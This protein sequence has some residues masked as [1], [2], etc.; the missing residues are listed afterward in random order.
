MKLVPEVA[1]IWYDELTH[2]LLYH[3]LCPSS[4]LAHV[5]YSGRICW[6]IIPSGCYSIY[7]IINIIIVVAAVT[8]PIYPMLPI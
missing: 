3:A 7:V 6:N 4:I 2:I 8:L 1:N 5:E